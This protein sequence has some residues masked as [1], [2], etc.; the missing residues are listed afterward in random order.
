M[1]WV[2]FT[3]ATV[4]LLSTLC[5]YK[6]PKEESNSKTFFYKR[7]FR[8]KRD[9]NIIFYI[10]KYHKGFRD[11]ADVGRALIWWYLIFSNIS[12]VFANNITRWPTS[13]KKARCFPES[14]VGMFTQQSQPTVRPMVL[15]GDYIILDLSHFNFLPPPI[16]FPS[17]APRMGRNLCRT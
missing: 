6:D 1:I 10:A 14:V 11:F 13:D 17:P 5:I 3:K 4:W 12:S 16:S 15:H 7:D 9:S 8:L 2:F